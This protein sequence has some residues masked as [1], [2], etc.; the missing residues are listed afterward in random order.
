MTKSISLLKDKKKKHT[1]I[2]LILCATLSLKELNIIETPNIP[3]TF[4]LS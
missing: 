4:T 1:A 3:Q 2:Y